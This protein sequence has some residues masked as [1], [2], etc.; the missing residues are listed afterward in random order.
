MNRQLRHLLVVYSDQIL[1]V[2]E[3]RVV[4]RRI[5][6]NIRNGDPIVAGP[7]FRIE[8]VAVDRP[9]RIRLAQ[10]ERGRA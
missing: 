3:A 7:S 4:K 1:S 5:R 9:V 10:A 8:S 2:E 6:A